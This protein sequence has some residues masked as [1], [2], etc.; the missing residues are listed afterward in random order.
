MTPLILGRARAFGLLT[1][2]TAPPYW[3][4]R[5]N[6]APLWGKLLGSPCPAG[7]PAD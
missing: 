5:P 1:G 3:S 4:L 6:S 2:S 7:G